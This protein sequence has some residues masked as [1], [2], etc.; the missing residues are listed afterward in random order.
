MRGQ[1]DFSGRCNGTLHAKGGKLRIVRREPADELHAV[2]HRGF[3][4]VERVTFRNDLGIHRYGVCNERIGDQRSGRLNNAAVERQRAHHQ[5]AFE[6]AKEIFAQRLIRYR[7]LCFVRCFVCYIRRAEFCVKDE[8]AFHRRREVIRPV[9]RRRPVQ[10]DRTIRQRGRIERFADRTTR[11]NRLR[12]T[13]IGFSV[14]HKGNR[15]DR[16]L[17]RGGLGYGGFRRSGL[18]HSG[19]RHSGFRRGSFRRGSLRRC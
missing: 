19:L 12:E 9:G 14:N 1:C 11:G 13:G 3:R 18:R 10:K 6:R 16:G 2:H 5:P 15:I 8:V 17:R 4:F 7:V